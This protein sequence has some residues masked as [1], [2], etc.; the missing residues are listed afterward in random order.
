MW[1]SNL[2]CHI[3]IDIVDTTPHTHHMLILMPVLRVI[4]IA[5][6]LLLKIHQPTDLVAIFIYLEE[7][8]H[9]TPFCQKARDCCSHNI[10]SSITAKLSV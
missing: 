9:H 2:E 6:T 8:A 10:E 3:S 4:F 1:Q 5:T 7:D